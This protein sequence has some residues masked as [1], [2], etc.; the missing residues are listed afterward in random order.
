MDAHPAPAG[1]QFKRI[2]SVEVEL[3]DGLV[4]VALAVRELLDLMQEG[5]SDFNDSIYNELF[6]GE[7]YI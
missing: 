6:E 5:F 2:L 1:F 3:R 7:C 4:V